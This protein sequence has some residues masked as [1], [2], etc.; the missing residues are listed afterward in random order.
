M[1]PPKSGLVRGLLVGF[2]A[3][4]LAGAGSA[5]LFLLMKNVS[6]EVRWFAGDPVVSWE[7][8]EGVAI[9]L[10]M[11]LTFWLLRPRG[12]PLPFLAA[13]YAFGA[14]AVGYAG[15]LLVWAMDIGFPSDT[16][17]KYAGH[18]VDRLVDALR[19]DPV[20]WLGAA[21]GV[22]PAFLLTLVR[23][24]RLRSRDRKTALAATPQ[25]PSQPE[26]RDPFE[27]AQPVESRTPNQFR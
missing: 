21:A 24:L 8:A 27:P 12:L 14:C 23:V 10:I 25:E 16:W 3:M 2:A 11:A 13:L 1:S 5:A 19:E 6:M 20:F 17:P 22:L 15:E 9:G 26:Y 18:G 7:V 4:I